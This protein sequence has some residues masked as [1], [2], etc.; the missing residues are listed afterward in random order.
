M[1]KPSHFVPNLNEMMEEYAEGEEEEVQ[2]TQSRTMQ[3][4]KRYEARTKIEQ[5][6]K[7]T[8]KRKIGA[9]EAETE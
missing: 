4:R 6:T 2:E 8:R 1:S 7:E 9:E 3:T 5:L